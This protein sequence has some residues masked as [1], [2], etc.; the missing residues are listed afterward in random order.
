MLTLEPHP[1]SLFEPDAPP[2]RLTPASIKIWLIEEIG[3]GDAGRRAVRCAAFSRTPPRA[4]VERVLVH[5]LGARHIVCGHDFAFGHGR[6]GTPELLLW[7][8]DEFDF[9]FTCVQEIRDEDGEPYSST[10]IRDHLRHGRP[11]RRGAAARSA[12]RRSRAR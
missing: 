10:R 9:G 7:L 6:K 12:V 11:G 5:G 3:P 4:F 1:R 2:F 8:G